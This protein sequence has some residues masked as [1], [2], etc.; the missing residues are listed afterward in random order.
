MHGLARRTVTVKLSALMKTVSSCVAE[1]SQRLT[2]PPAHQLN[3]HCPQ[4]SFETFCH[5]IATTKDDL[6]LM[7]NMNKREQGKF[8]SKG[9]FTVTQ[10]SYRYGRTPR[11]VGNQLQR[12]GNK[13]L[14]PGPGEGLHRRNQF[15]LLYPF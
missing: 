3:R 1:I 8:A 13:N 6:S 9:V 12:L 11:R 2:Q 10:L 4:C 5:G 14:F 15:V 7:A